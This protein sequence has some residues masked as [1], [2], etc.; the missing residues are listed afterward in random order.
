VPGGHNQHREQ[1]SG[2]FWGIGGAWRPFGCECAIRLGGCLGF[3][4]E[5]SSRD[6]ELHTASKPG[7]Q[8]LGSWA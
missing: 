2:D 8:V 5:H 6:A 1:C 4:L 3:R 7:V